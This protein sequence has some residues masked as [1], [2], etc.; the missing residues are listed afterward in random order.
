MN[1]PKPIQHLISYFRKF[2]GVGRKTA[3]RYAFQIITWSDDEVGKFAYFL[4]DL[5]KTLH[6]CQECGAILDSLSCKFCDS[7]SRDGSILCVISS[8]KDLFM[9]ESTNTYNGMYQVLT[10]QLSPLDDTHPSDEELLRLKTRI[11]KQHIKELIIA[12]DSTIEGDATALFLKK[13]LKTFDIMIT[14]LALG[15]PLGSSLEF[16]DEGTLSRALSTRTPM[17]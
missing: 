14:R 5:K 11:E 2:S 7:T 17:H 1:Y 12:L 16:L 13:E 8:P 6:L 3:E 9:I 4:K 10:S 15:M